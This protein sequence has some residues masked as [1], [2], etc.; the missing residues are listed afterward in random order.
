M[1]PR[2]D[3]EANAGSD[4]KLAQAHISLATG[5]LIPMPDQF[6]GEG[7]AR[8]DRSQKTLC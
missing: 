6:R 4:T 7:S 2:A 8:K 5:L 1:L 3:D